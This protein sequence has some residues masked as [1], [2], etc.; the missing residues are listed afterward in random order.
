MCLF[1]SEKSIFWKRK[2]SKCGVWPK[3]F[4]PQ[5]CDFD[6]FASNV[7]ES[8]VLALWW[9]SKHPQS[10]NISLLIKMEM[11]LNCPTMGGKVML[12]FFFSSSLLDTFIWVGGG[13]RNGCWPCVRNQSLHTPAR[14]TGEGKIKNKKRSDTNA[15]YEK[16]RLDQ[17]LVGEGNE[18]K[19]FHQVL[20]IQAAGS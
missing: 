13:G 9:I 19:P 1:K 15:P 4:C 14:E 12:T 3:G 11:W 10:W 17:Q 20:E 2:E 6:K 18:G 8:F 7:Y 5:Q 16:N